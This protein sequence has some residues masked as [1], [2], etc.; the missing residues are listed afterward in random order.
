MKKLFCLILVLLALLSGC[1]SNAAPSTESSVPSA[2]S[3][4]TDVISDADI[5]LMQIYMEDLLDGLYDHKTSVYEWEGGFAI[6]ISMEGGMNET[7]F[8]DFVIDGVATLQ[9]HL[10]EFDAPLYEFSVSFTISD[11]LTPSNNGSML[12]VTTDLATGMLTDTANGHNHFKP[13]ATPQDL[14]DMYGSTF[15]MGE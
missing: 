8:A 14:I 15:P 7:T 13:T 12:W 2:A 6:R 1:A 3:P 11:P 10:P 5:S 9:E 4:V